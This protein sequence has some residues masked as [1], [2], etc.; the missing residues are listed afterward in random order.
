[1]LKDRKLLEILY[2]LHKDRR[3]GVLRIERKAEKKQLVIDNGLLV[4]AESN[5]PVEHLARIMVKMELIP[6][7]EMKEI[8]SLMKTGKTSEEAILALAGTD[9]KVLEKGR[10]EQAIVILASVWAWEDCDIHLYPANGSVR[11]QLNLRL[12]LPE[13]LVLSVRRAVSDRLIPVSSRF[14]CGSFC[15]SED[16]AGIAWD[17][18]L[19]SAESYVYSLLQMPAIASD[20]LPLIP[21]TDGKPGELILRLFTLGLITMSESHVQTSQGPTGP[22]SNP[23]ADQL[24]DILNRCQTGSLYEILSVPAEASP[25]EIQ[26]AYHELAKQ[27]HPDRFQSGEVPEELRV[28]VEKVFASINEAYVTLKDPASRA[29]YDEKR[30]ASESKVEAELKARAGSRS[31]DEKTAESLYRDGRILLAEGNFERAVERLKGCVWL[32]PDNAIYHHYLGVAM[33]EIPKLRKSAEH[34]FLRALDL[35]SFF[36]DTHLE[37]AKLYIKVMLHRKASQQLQHLMQWDPDNQKAQKLWAEVRN[38][39]S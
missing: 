38:L 37:L 34:H 10:R 20:L 25:D 28:S 7:A 36:A 32:S 14:L 19:N 4:F 13:F 3:S 18:P 22:E 16:L 17:F 26:A 30:L 33:A 6:Q 9:L 24:G 35:N 12:P 31:E 2:T 5:L 27:Y 23:I 1:M 15:A 11:Y 21:E 39:S 8:A 29:R